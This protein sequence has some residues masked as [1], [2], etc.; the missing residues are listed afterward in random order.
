MGLKRPMSSIRSAKPILSRWAPCCSGTSA[1]INCRRFTM[2]V[3]GSVVAIRINCCSDFGDP[4]HGKA[5][6][7]LRGRHRAERAPPSG[8]ASITCS[9]SPSS[10]C[11]ASQTN[12]RDFLRSLPDFCAQRPRYTRAARLRRAILRRR[13]PSYWVAGALLVIAF[14]VGGVV[15]P[16][17]NFSQ[18]A[19]GL[20]EVIESRWTSPNAASA[21]LRR[22]PDRVGRVGIARSIPSMRT[23]GRGSVSAASCSA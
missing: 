5:V 9:G 6:P 17:S 10:S 15:L 14:G 2:P 3:S 11:S 12:G 18:G 13:I 8:S 4:V 23:W 7:R 16:A 20:W 1:L 22:A 21:K 19:A